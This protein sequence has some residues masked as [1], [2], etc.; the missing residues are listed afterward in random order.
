[1]QNRRPRQRKLRLLNWLT[2][3]ALMQMRV[4]IQHPISPQPKKI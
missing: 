3:R 2:Y 1:V 4:P